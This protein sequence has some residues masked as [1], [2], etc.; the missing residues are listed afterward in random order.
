MLFTKHKTFQ[1]YYGI[2]LNNLVYKD[3]LVKIVWS[4]RMIYLKTVLYLAPSVS[5][6]STVSR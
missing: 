4:L 6:M 3:N 2:C 1:I 5:I